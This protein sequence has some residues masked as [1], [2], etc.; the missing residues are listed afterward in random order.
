MSCTSSMAARRAAPARPRASSLELGAAVDGVDQL[1]RAFGDAEHVAQPQLRQA[2]REI[3][4][5][6][7]RAPLAAAAGLGAF[8]LVAF[9]LLARHQLELARAAARPARLARGRAGR[10]GDVEQPGPAPLA[11]RA[12]PERERTNAS[13]PAPQRLALPRS[14]AARP[15]ARRRAPGARTPA[16]ARARR[17]ARARRDPR[18]GQRIEAHRLAA[19]GDRRQHVLAAVGEQHAGG[20]T[21][22]APR[23]SSASGWPPGRSSCRPPS[24]TNT[25]RARLERRARRGRHDRLLDVADEHLRGAARRHPG[26]VGMRVRA[27]PARRPRP[28]RARRR[29]AARPRTRARSRACRCPAGRG[30]GRR[31]RARPSGASAGVEHRARVRVRVDAGQRRESARAAERRR[32]AS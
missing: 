2:Q 29:R 14:P 5:L 8:A 28:G 9:A 24:I 6:R 19:R 21:A 12:A 30:R 1:G 7:A 10:L 32:W 27:R 23:A 4:R 20:R 15:G 25:R 22:A 31:A 26:Q 17:P 18:R 13:A 3:E 16:R 11:G